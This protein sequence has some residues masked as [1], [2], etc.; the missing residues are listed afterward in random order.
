[1]SAADL[2]L[3]AAD[4]HIHI[5]RS[6]TG[7]PVKITAARDL[8]FENIARECVERK[9]LDLAGIVDCASPPVLADIR[10]LVESGEMVEQAGGGL[11]YRDHLTVLLAAEFETRETAGG[12]AHH[13]GYFPAL[14]GLS[15]FSREIGAHVTNR[16]L[17]SQA[18]GLPARELFD[19]VAACGGILCPAHC[20]TPHKSMYGTCVE[21]GAEMFGAA[22]ARIPAI[23]LGLSADTDLAD[24]FSELAG[25]TFLSNSDAH[26]LPKIAREYNL[27]ELAAP[28]FAEVLLA[29]RREGGRRVAGNFG[30]DPRLGK[31]HRTACEKCERIAQGQPPLLV[32][33]ACGSDRVV[34]GVL[35][36]I[37]SI[38]DLREPHH[39]PHRPPYHYQVPLQFVPG[40][41]A[42]ALRKLLNRFGSEMAVLHLAEESDL[43]LTVGAKIA[44]L[45]ILARE[46]RL[47][48]AAGGGG[49]YGKALPGASGQLGF[50]G[51]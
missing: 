37:L 17:S 42:V 18:C 47:A 15:D 45:I 13:L 44:R 8:T 6:S 25:K 14:A 20:F 28:T 26:S 39:P 30:L 38:A 10:H 1:M 3:F 16:E 2:A 36:R 34:V 31:Y 48:L 27:L 4:L 5:G 22:W 35:D 40:L 43:A 19:L 33:E 51:L 11:R 23:E 46:G 50:P 32:C 49:V 9:G 7:R 12:M 41:G 24:R 29:L 21:R